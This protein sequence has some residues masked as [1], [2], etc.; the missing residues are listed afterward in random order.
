MYTEAAAIADIIKDAQ[1]IV[2]LQADNP[3]GDSLGSAL[4]LEHILADMGKE[5]LLYCGV[6]MP[7]YLQ[8][9]EGPRR[10]RTAHQI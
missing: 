3:D 7:P 5:P 9:L 10:A 1:R 2:I 8:Y 6:D 4:A